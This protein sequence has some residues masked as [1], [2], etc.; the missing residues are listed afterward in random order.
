MGYIERANSGG[1]ILQRVR[2]VTM[3]WL[4]VGG[5]GGEEGVGCVFRVAIEYTGEEVVGISNVVVNVDDIN[6]RTR[7]RGV[8]MEREQEKRDG[9]TSSGLFEA[10]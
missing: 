7:I 10:I 3:L 2:Y 8:Y 5:E 4:V 9:L 6:I 1:V